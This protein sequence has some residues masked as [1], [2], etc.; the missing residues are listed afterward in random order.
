MVRSVGAAELFVESSKQVMYRLPYREC[1]LVFGG[2]AFEVRVTEPAVEQIVFLGMQFSR[3]I[4]ER[5]FSAE[6]QHVSP[7]GVGI[8]Q[9]FWCQDVINVGEEDQ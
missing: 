5:G 2:F 1:G 7:E 4:E 6:S 3:R 8:G 9:G